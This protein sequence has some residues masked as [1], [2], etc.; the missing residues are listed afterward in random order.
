MTAAKSL[1]VVDID[2]AELARRVNIRLGSDYTAHYVYNIHNGFSNSRRVLLAIRNILRTE[3]TP[4]HGAAN[5]Q[6]RPDLRPTVG[7]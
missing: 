2:Y 1:W 3:P 6:G 5:D 7:M 4:I